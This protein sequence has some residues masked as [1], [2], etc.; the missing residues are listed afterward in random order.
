VIRYL[1]NY[2]V[3][4]VI[5]PNRG[6][7]IRIFNPEFFLSKVIIFYTKIKLTL[8]ILKDLGEQVVAVGKI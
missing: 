2:S 3:F 4:A 6:S 5:T 7:L 8:S 1:K